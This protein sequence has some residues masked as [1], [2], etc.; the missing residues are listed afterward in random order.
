MDGLVLQA[1]R[2]AV[3][4]FVRDGF[5]VGVGSGSTVVYAAERLGELVREQNLSLKC[6]PTSFQSRQV[7]CGGRYQCARGYVK[8]DSARVMVGSSLRRTD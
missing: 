3:D 5:V 2:Q 1:A 8:T 4:E 7:R 6:I